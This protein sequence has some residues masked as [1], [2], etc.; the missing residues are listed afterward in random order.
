MLIDIRYLQRSELLYLLV[1]K[2]LI[3]RYKSSILGYIWALANP[4]AFAL[5]YYFAFKVVMRV[6][7][8]NYSIF[9]LT[10]MFPWVWMTNGLV[11]AT[12][13]FR[14]NLS[15]VKKVN[16]FL[17]VLPLSNITHEM[18][19][20]L[21]AMPVLALFILL[22][23]SE[24]HLTW[25]WQLPLMLLLQFSMLY[26]VALIL[27]LI[28]V[29]VNDVE[30]LVGIGLSI[31]FFLTPIVYPATIAPEKFQV[32]F[33]WSPPAQ[34]ILAWRSVFLHGDIALDPVLFCFCFAIITSF[35][36]YFVY[37]KLSPKLGEL[38]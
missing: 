9:L 5:A 20:F 23:G 1:K 25:F 28:N 7:M 31:L 18:V 6:E 13:S 16:V 35:I 27:A 22:T 17:A 12:A 33:N 4:C 29:Y 30:Y 15:L 37:L 34:L 19:H 8:P 24:L 38:L 10:G 32:Y 26:P 21:F 11:Q 36:S 3:V 2:E 14:N